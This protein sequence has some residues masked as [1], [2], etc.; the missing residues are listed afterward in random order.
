MTK[1]ASY[2][3]KF[4]NAANL[5]CDLFSLQ[6]RFDSAQTQE[7]KNTLNAVGQTLF[8]MCEWRRAHDTEQDGVKIYIG[9]KLWKLIEHSAER[10]YKYLNVDE[11]IWPS[12]RSAFLELLNELNITE[13]IFS[14][15]SSACMETLYFLTKND[16][17]IV[18]PVALTYIRRGNPKG[19]FGLHIKKVKKED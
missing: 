3:K 7:E 1:S 14:D 15:A 13:L 16:W 11:I 5:A 4:G 10:G 8:D 18:G 12:E 17:K 2:F 6:E 19:T 9:T